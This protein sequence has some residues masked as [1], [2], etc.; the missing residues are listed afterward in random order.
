M[1]NLKLKILYNILIIFSNLTLMIFILTDSSQWKNLMVVI[2]E[3]TFV[4][5]FNIIS[6]K[7]L[8]VLVFNNYFFSYF[9]KVTNKLYY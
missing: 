7:I 6:A 8:K 4:L 9:I 1:L 2:Y 3:I 5:N